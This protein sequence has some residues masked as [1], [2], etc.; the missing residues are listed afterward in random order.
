ML[1]TARPSFLNRKNSS[2]IHTADADVDKT[3]EFRRVFVGDVNRAL[4][5]ADIADK[6]RHAIYVTPIVL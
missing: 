5:V 2:S 4:A 1:A 6:L 3:V